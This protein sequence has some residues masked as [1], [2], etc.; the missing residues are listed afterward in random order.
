MSDVRITRMGN[1]VA[2]LF[3][4]KTEVRFIRVDGTRGVRQMA[5]RRWLAY[6]KAEV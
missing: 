5:R 2:A 6:P 4:T 1:L 3:Y